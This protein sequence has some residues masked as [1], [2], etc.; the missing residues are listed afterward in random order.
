[1]PHARGDLLAPL[2][3][4]PEVQA[5]VTEARAAVDRLIAHKI[6]RTRSAQVTAEASLRGARASAALEGVEL[7]LEQ[8]RSQLSSG[9]ADA[10]SPI[11]AGAIRLYAELA[12]LLGTWE[13]APR[14][15]L[16]RMHVLAAA[17]LL[18]EEELGR[19]RAG[20]T[21]DD[22][23]GL[24]AA[25]SPGEVAVRLDALADLVVGDTAAP[26]LVLAAVVEGELLAL[27]PFLAANGLVARAAAR[28][29]HV[30]RGLD[31]KSLSAPEVGHWELREEYAVSAREYAEG[32]R[33][34][35]VGWVAHCARAVCLGA[36]EGIAV[37][38]AI[39]RG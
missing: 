21:E 25:P 8:L 1:M 26:A 31:P 11:V 13:R 16:A 2:V 18:P 24:G 35:V 32:G 29:V 37:C 36:R 20:G 17:G 12:G 5:A 22:P 15:A 23:L 6:L 39:T 33:A 30:T 14:Q 4:V 7:S 38:E 34:G 28:L 19:P 27:R 10:H 3:A 9:Q